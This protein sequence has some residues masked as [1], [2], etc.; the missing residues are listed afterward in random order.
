MPAVGQI[1]RKTRQRV[2]KLFRDVLRYDYLG[3]W[4]DREGNANIEL[5]LLRKWLT[6]Q[7]VADALISVDTEVLKSAVRALNQPSCRMLLQ[8]L[9]IS[10]FQCGSAR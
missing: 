7:G 1:E 5:E 8:L 3:N 9:P 4:I 2:V 6:R 10:R